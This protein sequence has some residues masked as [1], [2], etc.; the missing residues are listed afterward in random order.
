MN[1]LD[2]EMVVADLRKRGYEL[3]SDVKAADTILYNTCSVRAHAEDKVYSALGTLKLMKK[4]N[5]DKIIGV[6]GCMAQKDQRSYL[7]GPH[8][9][10]SSSAPDNCNRFPI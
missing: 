7:T 4:R 6:M 3:T 10:I 1:M 5:P 9:L 8:L 2:S